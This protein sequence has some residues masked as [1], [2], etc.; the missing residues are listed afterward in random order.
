MKEIISVGFYITFKKSR[1]I[2]HCCIW[3][4]DLQFCA[5]LSVLET[6]Y[7]KALFIRFYW[8]NV[9][10]R[11]EPLYSGLET[12]R[13]A[14]RA[15]NFETRAKVAIFKKR[16]WLPP[17]KATYPILICH[18]LEGNMQTVYIDATLLG[19]WAYLV[20][21]EAENTMSMYEE[22]IIVVLVWLCWENKIR[23]G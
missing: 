15:V 6:L 2:A 16:P 8:H 3:M 4:F 17:Y 7:Q 12:Q 19:I 10:H 1:F 20:E 14:S 18:S 13:K 9:N 22:L 21:D 11:K 5:R 23:T